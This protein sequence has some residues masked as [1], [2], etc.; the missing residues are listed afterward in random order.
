MERNATANPLLV[1]SCRRSSCERRS[2]SAIFFSLRNVC[3]IRKR[4]TGNTRTKQD[5]GGRT[6]KRRI[7]MGWERT[8]VSSL[9]SLLCHSLRKFARNLRKMIAFGVLRRRRVHLSRSR[10]RSRKPSRDEPRDGPSLLVPES[11]FSSPSRSTSLVSTSS[12]IS[13]SP[14][15]T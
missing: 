10:E 4:E 14:R 12:P 5:R 7:V 8:L 11:P 6:G 13:S 2:W 1:F 9:F 15:P 3:A